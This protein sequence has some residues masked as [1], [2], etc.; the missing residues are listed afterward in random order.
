M[1]LVVAPQKNRSVGAVRNLKAHDVFVER[2]YA[3]DIGNGNAD[4]A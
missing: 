3:L 2:R 1:M 4:M